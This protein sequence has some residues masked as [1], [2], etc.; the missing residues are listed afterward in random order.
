MKLIQTWFSYRGQ[1][2]LLDFITT[3][4]APGILLGIGAMML[5]NS[6][7]AQGKII[8]SYLAFSIWPASAM[9]WKLAISQQHKT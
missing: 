2:R 5:D 3:G 1:M 7:E 6:L 8:F 4:F 9:L